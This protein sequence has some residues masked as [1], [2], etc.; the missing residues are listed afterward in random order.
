MATVVLLGTLDTKGEEYGFLRDRLHE[1]GIETVIVDVGVFGGSGTGPDITNEEVARAAG[2]EVGELA[3]S[4]DRGRAIEAMSRG[5]AEVVARLHGEGRL[6]GVMALGG[7]GGSALA[8]YAMRRLPVGVPKLMVSTVASGDTRPYVGATDITMTYSVVDIAGIN[9]VSAR[10]LTN[11]AGAIA[12]MVKAPP[13]ELREARPLVGA[14]MFGV[15]TQAVDAARRELDTL[16]YEVLVFHQTG[17]GGESME[18]L[19]SDGYI[20]AV[21][22]V[23]LTEFCDELV[24]GVFPAC[25]RRLES[26]GEAGIPQVV[27][28]GALDMVNFGP[29]ESVPERFRDRNLYVHNPTITLM[30]TTPEECAGMGRHIAAK[31]NAAK[32][33]VSLFMPLK[34]VSAIATEGQ[35][36]HDPAA[37]EALFN[38]LRE[39]L[40]ANVEV[41]E[42]ETDINDA[43]FAGAMAKKLDEYCRRGSEEGREG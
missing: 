22:D 12:G 20:T 4:R 26:A 10:I 28:P 29:L 5:A 18:A 43:V 39:N 37:D 11:A 16:G 9:V 32:G 25:K 23:T 40:G 2:E 8:T 42:M 31:L 34:G 3:A 14:S 19:I 35:P 21:L 17:T 33:P 1:T 6:D 41:V 38:A 27:S 15:T 13:P 7:S 24:G 30:R 36:F